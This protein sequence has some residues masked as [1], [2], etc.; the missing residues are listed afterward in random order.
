M[1]PVSQ[2]NRLT[3]IHRCALYVLDLTGRTGE[4]VKR[5]VPVCEYLQHMVVHRSAALTGKVEVRVVGHCHKGGGIGL[6]FVVNNETVVF[7][8]RIG[9]P[10]VQIAGITLLAVLGTVVQLDLIDALLHHLPHLGVETLDAAMQTVGTVV[11]RQFINFQLS[12]FI[13]QLKYAS[14][15][16]V[17]YS[18]ADSIEIGLLGTPFVRGT[19]AKNN[20]LDFP[21]AVSDQQFSDLCPEI[22]DLHFQPPTALNRIKFYETH[23]FQ[24]YTSLNS[25]LSTLNYSNLITPSPISAT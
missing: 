25:Q 19:E 17:S 18:S 4:L 24:L 11:D 3:E 12:T 6:G 2:T 16:A 10:Y 23:N 14:L 21:F 20:V 8:R 1:H 7:G 22:R 9:H 13:F 15:D 5:R